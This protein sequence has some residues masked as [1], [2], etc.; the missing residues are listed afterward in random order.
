MGCLCGPRLPF[1]L[2]SLPRPLSSKTRPQGETDREADD[3]GDLIGEAGGDGEVRPLAASPA[4]VERA[5]ISARYSSALCSHLAFR[6]VSSMG[7]AL[8]CGCEAFGI[9]FVLW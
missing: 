1:S 3:G 4:E 5:F 9:V 7:F 8:R 6:G 2:P